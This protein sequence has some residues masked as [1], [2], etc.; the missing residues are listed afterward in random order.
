MGYGSRAIELLQQYYEMKMVDVNEENGKKVSEEIDPVED[1]DLGI[2]SE[3]VSPRKNLPPLLLK[4]TERTPEGI[5]YMGV[6]YGMTLPLLKFWK[7]LGFLPVYLRQTSNELTGEH[8]CIMIK[9]LDSPIMQQMNSNWLQEY[10]RDFCR[11]Y[12]SLLGFQFRNFPPSLALSIL[13]NKNYVLSTSAGILKSTVCSKGLIL[14]SLE[15]YYMT[16]L[17]CTYRN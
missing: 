5:H 15:V 8:S 10:F 4:L 17:L 13:Q 6:S 9:V 7:R 1:Q 12:V 14:M 16:L 11:R 3:R 2:V